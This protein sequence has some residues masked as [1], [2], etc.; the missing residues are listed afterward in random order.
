M[1]FQTVKHMALYTSKKAVLVV[2]GR[3]RGEETGKYPG[4]HSTVSYVAD[5]CLTRRFP[6]VPWGMQFKNKLL[7]VSI[8]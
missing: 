6:L 8:S 2:K 7:I 3:V 4:I 1:Y 5:F